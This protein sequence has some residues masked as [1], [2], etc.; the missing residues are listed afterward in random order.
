MLSS[1]KNKS[2]FLRS[3]LKNLKM[4]TDLQQSTD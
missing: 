2:K 3:Q 1:T 4:S